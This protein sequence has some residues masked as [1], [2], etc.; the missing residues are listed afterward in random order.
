M[1]CISP[2]QSFSLYAILDRNKKRYAAL[3]WTHVDEHDK[4][5]T[6]GLETVRRDNCALVRDVIQTS[7]NKILI[8]RK[9]EGAIAYVKQQISDLAIPKQNGFFLIGHYKIIE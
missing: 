5:D 4:M 6:K 9:V 1:G 8:D 7:L 3:M 2:D